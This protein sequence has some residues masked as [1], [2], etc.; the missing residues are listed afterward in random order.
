MLLPTRS[1]TE[2]WRRQGQPN[3]SGGS[4]EAGNEAMS[5]KGVA[6]LRDR[7]SIQAPAAASIK[8]RDV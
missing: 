1:T 3:R 6:R 8:S 5:Q 4:V 2:D 7:G